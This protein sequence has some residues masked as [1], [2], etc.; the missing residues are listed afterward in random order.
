[1]FLRIRNLLRQFRAWRGGFFWLPCPV[2]G[3]YFAGYEASRYS[4]ATASYV[5]SL[6]V[7]RE[8][9]GKIVCQ[10]RSCAIETVR[11]NY[12]AFGII[13]WSRDD[14]TLIF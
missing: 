1:M 13:P 9:S 12:H 2:C 11:R 3:E 10:K 7:T 14:E 4:L 6:G 5:D 8:Q